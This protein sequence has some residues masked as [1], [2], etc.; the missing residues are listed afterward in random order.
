MVLSLNNCPPEYNGGPQLKLGGG[1]LHIFLL[2]YS[3]ELLHPL[4]WLLDILG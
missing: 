4:F 2:A 1:N 3:E